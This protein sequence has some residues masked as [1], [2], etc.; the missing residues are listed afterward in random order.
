MDSQQSIKL[1]FAGFLF[2][3][4]GTIVDSTTAIVKHWEAIG[5]EIGVSPQL[6]LET[7][8]GRRSI[9]TFKEIAPDKATWEYVGEVEGKIPLLYGADA[10]EIP[11]ARSLLEDLTARSA[12]WAIVTSGTAPLASGWLNVLSLPKPEHLVTAESV[13]EGKPDPS[14]YLMGLEKLGILKGNATAADVLVLEDSPA[15]IKAGKAAGC[16]VIGLV[17]SHRL[18]QVAAAEPD[19]VVKDLESV[20]VVTSREGKVI[21]EISHPLQVRVSEREREN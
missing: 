12:P 4:D 14:C 3:L 6:I 11:G 1:P 21:V 15:G 18:E 2:D 17:T 16:Q 8:H 20:R 19:W 9:D 13:Q 10:V 5:T 7:S